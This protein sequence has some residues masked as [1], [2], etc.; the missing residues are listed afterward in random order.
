MVWRVYMQ[1]RLKLAP[2]TGSCRLP[3]ESARKLRW[4]DKGDLSAIVRDHLREKRELQQTITHL[5]RVRSGAMWS[6]PSTC[7]CGAPVQ[8][9][10]HGRRSMA[11]DFRVRENLQLA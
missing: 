7:A 10:V 6:L 9:G 1:A 3:I 2:S 5:K 11:D 4:Y 8:Q